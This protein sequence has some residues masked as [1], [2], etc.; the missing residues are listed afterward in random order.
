[1]VEVDPDRDGQRLDNFLL[2]QLK[3]VPRSMVY[4]LVR[5]GQ[6]RV[7]G[8]RCKPDQRLLAGQSVRIP[9]VR[10]ASAGAPIAASASTL[11]MLEQ[12]ILFEDEDLLVLNKP[13]GLAAHG[14]SG[15]SYGA[16]EALRQL[17]PQA[18][19]ELVHRLDRDTSGLML[20]AKRRPVLLALQESLRE[21]QVDK[22]YLSLLVGRI[23]RDRFDVN[24]PLRKQVLSG[25]ERMVQ[26]ASDGKAS[27]SRYR[28][29]ERFASCTLVE[30]K[31]ETGRTHQIRV[32]SQHA[33]HP[34]AGDGKYGDA[35]GNRLLRQAGLDRLFLHAASMKVRLPGNAQDSLWSAPLPDSLHQV[36]TALRAEVG[37]P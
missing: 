5:S 27:L 18:R 1:M 37:P 23:E 34:V 26:V 29:L 10:E 36:I 19:L 2:G 11:E 7:D 6:V 4:R 13:S 14:G 3:G 33:G 28:V 12:A 21:G 25:G 20:V 15:V 17:R 22:R 30:V 31:I 9:P 32:H 16:I 35:E 8:A 24:A